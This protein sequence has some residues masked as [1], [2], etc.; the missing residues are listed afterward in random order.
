LCAKNLPETLPG[1][2]GWVDRDKLYDF[3]GRNRKPQIQLA[4]QFGFED[5]AQHAGGCCFLTDES[6]SKK[7]G[8]LWKARGE[9]RYEL[10]DIMLLKV[11][12]HIRPKPNFKLIVSREEGENNF[13]R[14]YRHQFE[15]MEC[16]SHPGPLTLL[17]G[18]LSANDYQTAAKVLARYRKGRNEEKVSVPLHQ[19]DG[20]QMDLNVSPF[21]ANEIL[22]DWH[23]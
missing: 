15:Y 20:T 23:I 2:E 5:F 6:Y 21:N 22:P 3:S 4:Q 8:D 17:D 14:G 16:I 7:L 10:D 19:K 11:G 13:L 1:R 18:E 12:R 9:R